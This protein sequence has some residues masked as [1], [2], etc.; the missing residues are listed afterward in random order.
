M[1]FLLTFPVALSALVQPL[2]GPILL[3][4]VRFGLRGLDPAEDLGL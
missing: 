2:N 1:I 4:F 3:S